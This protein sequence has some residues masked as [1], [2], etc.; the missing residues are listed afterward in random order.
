MLEH[1]LVT[2][3]GSELSE[4]ALEAARNLVPAGAKIT[5]LTV[6]D[7][8]DVSAY[9]MYPM[10]VS[11]DYYQDALSQ[12]EKGAVDYVEKIATDLR[13]YGYVV[14]TVTAT[15]VAADVIIERAA[16]LKVEAIVMSTHGRSGFNQWLFGS[17]TQKVLSMTPC[18]V[19]V[20]PGRMS[21]RATR[22]MEK[23]AA[24]EEA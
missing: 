7:L 2:V 13:T 20:I 12:A 3:D 14:D 4:K 1:I 11:M 22:E 17:V 8:P 6:V 15:G 9:S 24:A 19:F 10:S 5:L 18:P 16:E 21:K 23:V